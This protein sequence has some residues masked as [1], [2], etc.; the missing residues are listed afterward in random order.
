M[1]TDNLANQTQM[2]KHPAQK[3]EASQLWEEPSSA[4]LVETH[5]SALQV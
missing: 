2:Q 5:H 3:G 1:I 4:E